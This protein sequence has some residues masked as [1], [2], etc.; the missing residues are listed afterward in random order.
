MWIIAN[1]HHL[2][3]PPT[4]CSAESGSEDSFGSFSIIFYNNLRLN[5]HRR[6]KSNLVPIYRQISK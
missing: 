4:I 6:H 1:Q 3:W 5:L 2:F